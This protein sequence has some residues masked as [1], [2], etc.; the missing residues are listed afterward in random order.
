MPDAVTDRRNQIHR[1]ACKLFRDKGFHGTSIRDIAEEVGLLGGSLYNHITSKDDLLWE[2]VDA[3]AERFFSALRPIVDS[4]LGTLQK[5]RSAMIAHV[6][7]IAEDL[8]AAAVFTV[9][10]RH[11]S[12]ERRAAF[13][14][15]R[16]DYEQMFRRLVRAAIHDRLLSVQDETTATLFIFSTL[17]HMFTW[18]KTDGPLTAE[19]VGRVMSDYILDG[20]KRRTA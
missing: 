10:W 17:N 2:I 16:N 6:G 1:V 5:L 19:D 20:L 11:L 3:A 12:P 4:G 15:R 13:T 18:F 8:D 9:E 14:G 7:V